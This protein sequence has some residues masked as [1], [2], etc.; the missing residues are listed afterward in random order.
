MQSV[1]SLLEAQG[2]DMT[3]WTLS[4][5]TGISADGITIVGNGT[6][7]AGVPEAWISRY[8]GL[9]TPQAAVESVLA[10]TSVADGL[11]F[12]LDRSSLHV[13]VA[14]NHRCDG[15]D[16]SIT[17]GFVYGMVDWYRND[18]G[19][20]SG[21]A[22]IMV[23]LGDAWSAG[24]SASR[25]TIRQDLAFSGSSDFDML[26]GQAFLAR[27]PQTGLQFVVTAGS[28]RVN[29]E[30][31]RGYMNGAGTTTSRGETSGRSLDFGARIGIARDRKD[32]AAAVFDGQA[33]TRRDQGGEPDDGAHEAKPEGKSHRY[34]SKL[35]RGQNVAATDGGRAPLGPRRPRWGTRR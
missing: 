10:I 5:A 25:G 35:R 9:I 15:S 7:P 6:N 26:T 21:T 28:G 32:A 29:G 12:S 27:M 23:D 30:I 17:C 34:L 20:L 8:A 33:K 31:V 24:V 1:S 3:N 14:R 16:N 4:S 22:G 19:A 2:V 11:I 18:R 13:E